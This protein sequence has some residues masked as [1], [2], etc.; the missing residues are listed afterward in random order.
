VGD[1]VRQSIFEKSTFFFAC[2]REYSKSM[3]FE[4]KI[5]IDCHRLF[6][7]AAWPVYKLEVCNVMLNGGEKGIPNSWHIQTSNIIQCL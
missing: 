3:V 2:E 1:T 7:E 6:S 4:D 5:S